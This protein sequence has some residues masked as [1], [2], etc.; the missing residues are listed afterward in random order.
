LRTDSKAKGAWKNTAGGGMQARPAGGSITGFRAGQPEA[1][2]SGAFVMDDMIKPDDAYSEVTV[3]TIN[4]RFNGVFRS[5]LMQERVTPMIL[6]MQRIAQNDPTNFLLTGGTGEK[7]HHLCL[8]ALYDKKEPYPE[9]YTHGI[10]IDPK[11]ENGP[12]WP[13]KHNEEELE[14]LDT[15]DPYVYQAQYKQA[16]A[17][18]GGGIFKDDWWQYYQHGTVIPEFRII[19][20]DTAQKTKERNDYSC[21]QL[22]GYLKGDLY[23]MDLIKGRWEAP[24]LNT[25]FKLFWSKHI[26]T[27]KAATT[28]RLR[29]AAIE[30]KS[31]GTGLIQFMR[32]LKGQKIPMKAVQRGTDKLTRAMDTVPYLATGRIHIPSD[33]PF[34]LDFKNEFSKFSSDDTHAFDD[35][36]DPMMDACDLLLSEN[37]KSAGVW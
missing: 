35:Q 16:P 17:T 25:N 18:L 13:F 2:F 9:D 29:Y 32:K 31:S 23:L 8:P 37:S 14:N 6:I 30:D 5:R 1:G 22:W 3:D 19:T 34:T 33:A 15:A 20:G 10:S 24:E 26:G 4:K 12:I 21:F 11:L 28:N 27:G 7:W 36:I